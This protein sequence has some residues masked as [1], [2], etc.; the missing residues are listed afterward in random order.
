[1]TSW[2]APLLPTKQKKPNTNWK[3]M[4]QNTGPIVASKRMHFRWLPGI[5]GLLRFK[6][7]Q[8][9][10]WHVWHVTVDLTP[11]T[12]YTMLQAIPSTK[13]S[14]MKR[15]SLK[16]LRFTALYWRVSMTSTSLKF[17]DL[18]DLETGKRLKVASGILRILRNFSDPTSNQQ[19]LALFV[20]AP[21][22]PLHT[23]ATHLPSSRRAPSRAKA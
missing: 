9:H 11:E 21:Q 2:S 14:Q 16:V 10:V 19:S 8:T 6:I 22:L 20:H 12:R 23:E 13:A 4:D 7:F 1:M 5:V 15:G 17:F 3:P 18:K